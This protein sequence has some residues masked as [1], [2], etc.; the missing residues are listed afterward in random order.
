MLALARFFDWREA[1]VVV[2]PETFLRWHRSAY[3]MFW[4]GK[5]RKADRPLLPKNLRELI[6]EMAR[7][8]STWGEQR[9]ADELRVKLGI[10]VSP[11]NVRKYVDAD[12]PRGNSG[13]RW[14]T[15]V[16]GF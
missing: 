12:R 16:R 2:K 8:N 13:Q 15:F 9:I 6:R 14:S 5:S 4:R 7:D 10:R 1:L 11:R 3:R